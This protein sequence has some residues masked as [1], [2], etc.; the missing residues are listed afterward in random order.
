MLHPILSGLGICLL[1][2]PASA[3]FQRPHAKPLPAPLRFGGT[4]RVETGEWSPPAED[5]EPVGMTIYN[6]DARQPY[7]L[8]VA[9][10]QTVT[11]FGSV[12]RMAKPPV[13]GDDSYDV[14]GFQFAYCTSEVR[15]EFGYLLSFYRDYAGCTTL[16][17]RRP[18][19]TIVLD[20]LPGARRP[21]LA[22]CWIVTIDLRETELAFDLDDPDAEAG[23]LGLQDRF[24]WSITRTGRA[25]GD[26]GPILAGDPLGLYGPAAPEGAGTD[27]R[28]VTGI[29]GTGLGSEDAFWVEDRPAGI[30]GCQDGVPGLPISY[31]S[32]HLQVYAYTPPPE[33]GSGS[34]LPV[35]GSNYCTD[36]RG[37]ITA[38]GSR[39]V[40][41][42]CLVLTAQTIQPT[43]F[44]LFFYGPQRTLR[45]HHLGVICVGGGLTRLGPPAAIDETGFAMRTVDLYGESQPYS[46]IVLQAP[47]TMRFQFW[48]RINIWHGTWDSTLTN[49]TEI[50][51]YP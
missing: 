40:S 17:E 51:F 50:R 34:T 23:G 8:S 48:Y 44:G 4:F 45:T 36:A 9:P 15:G 16:A 27:W 41:D 1:L 22:A 31:G 12:P 29:P 25:A 24:G 14:N 5:A 6:N 26:G 43:S 33:E 46:E 47:V 28:G 18:A 20:D 7:F 32:F 21:G 39:S 38:L 30:E 42:N 3:Q 10:W 2:A 19:T 13:A 37:T 35:I 49:A 11:D